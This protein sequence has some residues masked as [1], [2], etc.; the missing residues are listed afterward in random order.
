[1]HSSMSTQ[2]DPLSPG[3][4]PS[5]SSEEAR[6]LLNTQRAVLQA[7]AINLK[8]KQIEFS[9]SKKNHAV[10]FH[11]AVAA[12][13][14]R[15]ARLDAREEELIGREVALSSTPVV[16]CWVVEEKKKTRKPTKAEKKMVK[17]TRVV[18]MRL[19]GEGRLYTSQ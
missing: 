11:K 19:R 15:K 13:M 9:A 17:N 18:W 5:A 16:K 1:M 8:K 12:L 14:K 2:T 7:A 10:M 4:G 6:R 3:N